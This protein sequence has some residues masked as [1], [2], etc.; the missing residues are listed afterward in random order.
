[1]KLLTGGFLKLSLSA[2][3]TK[4]PCIICALFFSITVKERNTEFHNNEKRF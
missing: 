3:Y 2:K 4:L 1:M